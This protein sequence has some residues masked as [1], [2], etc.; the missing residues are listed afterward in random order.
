MSALR[1]CLFIGTLLIST[2]CRSGVPSPL[3]AKNPR[4]PSSSVRVV[5]QIH[6]APETYL[7][8]AGERYAVFSDGIVDLA[9]GKVAWSG[10]YGYL[11]FPAPPDHIVTLDLDWP[12]IRIWSLATG[13]ERGRFAGELLPPI[14]EEEVAL[15]QRGQATAAVDTLQVAEIPVSGIQRPATRAQPSLSEHQRERIAQLVSCDLGSLRDISADGLQLLTGFTPG[16]LC[17]WSVAAVR[18]QHCLSGN[19]DPAYL[20]DGSS[21][22]VIHGRQ[23]GVWDLA[24]NQIAWQPLD[25]VTPSVPRDVPT[26][27]CGFSLDKP[28]ERSLGE[29]L[30]QAGKLIVTFYDL[31]ND[32]WAVVRADGRY[33]GTAHATDYLAFFAADGTLLDGSAVAALRD[34]AAV[35]ATVRAALACQ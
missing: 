26:L 2:A 33:T 11:R 18:R 9:V 31:T 19:V 24:T 20:R 6:V 23:Q 17:H 25:E 8:P 14:Q 35:S 5:P 21:A 32:E 15:L 16:R 3:Q 7:G 22:I 10:N 28:G 27:P 1:L 34:E 12:G 30:Y 29:S 13:Q 4:S